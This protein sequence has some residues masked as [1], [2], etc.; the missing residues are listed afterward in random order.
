MMQLK[1]K[2]CSPIRIP[3]LIMF[4]PQ[5]LVLKLLTHI[6]LTN[7][8]AHIVV[9]VI[10]RQQ[11]IPELSLVVDNKCVARLKYQIP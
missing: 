4:C 3:T 11:L 7:K 2:L 8:T 1:K 10:Y 6:Q 9:L 5:F